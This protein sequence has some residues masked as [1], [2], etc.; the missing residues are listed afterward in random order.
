MAPREFVTLLLTSDNA[1][2]EASTPHVESSRVPKKI[3]RHYMVVS[4]PVDHP[5]SPPRQGLVRGQYESIELI[6]EIPVTRLKSSSTS[7]LLDASPDSLLGRKR[8]TTVG[9]A[10]SRALTGKG[11]MARFNPELNPVEWIM[12]TR[13][14]PGGGIPRFMVERGTPSSIVA[15]AAKF[16]DWACSFDGIPAE[17]EGEDTPNGKLDPATDYLDPNQRRSLDLRDPASVARRTSLAA[18]TPAPGEGGVISSLTHAVESGL[19]NFA[20]KY[21][22]DQF[23]SSERDAQS[24]DESTDSSSVDSFASAEQF[25]TAPEPHF[26]RSSTDDL[27]QTSNDISQ[28]LE[29]QAGKVSEL[30]KLDHQAADLD[31]K[32]AKYREKEEERLKQVSSRG[33][34]EAAKARDRL[35]RE[36]RK[37]EER[38]NKELAKLQQRRDKELRK[39]EEKRQKAANRDA[40]QRVQRERDE[41]KIHLELLKKEND[42]LKEQVGH[43]QRENTTLVARFGKTPEGQ[44]TLQ[45]VKQESLGLLKSRGRAASLRSETSGSSRSPRL[46]KMLASSHGSGTGSMSG[47]KEQQQQQQQRGGTDS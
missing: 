25:T 47:E 11:G 1:L 45:L 46:D 20:P 16:I 23:L 32:L 18:E 22:R 7:N 14:D 44:K 17:D 42:M 35:D 39:F 15:D 21:V 31:R 5:D 38:H 8:S 10:E 34:K 19:A 33:E 27:S 28:S 2:G 36:L 9:Y 41:A 4:R 30:A 43:L 40:L 13:S 26:R 29:I 24:D 12:V 37:R 3:P 6:R